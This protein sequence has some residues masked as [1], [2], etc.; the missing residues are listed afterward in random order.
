MMMGLLTY[1]TTKDSK[2]Y[3]SDA[4][5]FEIDERSMQRRRPD[6]SNQSRYSLHLCIKDN[7]LSPQ[8]TSRIS[9]RRLD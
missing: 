5:Y 1:I 4:N 7:L 8:R 6:G 2:R 9:N 3:S